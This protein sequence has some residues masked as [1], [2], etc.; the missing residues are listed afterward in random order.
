MP[1]C[2]QKSRNNNQLTPAKLTYYV[3]C[4][5]F[6]LDQLLW[7]GVELGWRWGVPCLAWAPSPGDRVGTGIWGTW[8]TS[9][10]ND[11]RWEKVEPK[12]ARDE[13]KVSP[14]GKLKVVAREQLGE[15]VV[16][17]VPKSRSTRWKPTLCSP[18]EFCHLIQQR[19]YRPQGLD[20]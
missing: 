13:N 1:Q 2:I 3:R 20:I 16:S 8:A 15:L 7:E 19:R 18:G 11:A 4:F 14:P 12:L 9:V 6:E 17:E 5:S 10:H